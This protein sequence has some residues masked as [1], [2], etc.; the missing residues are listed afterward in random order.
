MKHIYSTEAFHPDSSAWG[1]IYKI[2]A[3]HCQSGVLTETLQ[4]LV[5]EILGWVLYVDHKCPDLQFVHIFVFHLLRF[6]HNNYEWKLSG[7]QYAGLVFALPSFTLV[8]WWKLWINGSLLL[9]IM[10]A[11]LFVLSTASTGPQWIQ[12]TESELL[13]LRH[14]VTRIINIYTSIRKS[15]KSIRCLCI[16]RAAIAGNIMALK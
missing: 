12:L 4:F 3:N 9:L 16:N 14:I 11:V 13:I 7:N 2:Y 1:E 5:T 15:L 8:T 6:D 10:V